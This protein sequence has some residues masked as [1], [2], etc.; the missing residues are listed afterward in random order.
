MFN[1]VLVIVS[2]ALSV[3]LTVAG[4]LLL[5]PSGSRGSMAGEVEALYNEA[6]RIS[7]AQQMWRWSHFGASPAD[8]GELVTGQY[9][10]TAP[11]A[12]WVLQQGVLK[13]TLP[14]AAL[15]MALNRRLGQMHSNVPACNAVS[16]ADR[17]VCCS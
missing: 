10:S 6:M 5:A 9:L 12:G 3:A 7:E 1:L 15:C 2:V 11:S 13:V 17:G 16:E 14:D 8:I 4:V